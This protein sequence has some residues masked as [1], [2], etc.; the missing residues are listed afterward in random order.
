M[1]LDCGENWRFLAV[2]DTG[3]RL[4]GTE[5]LRYE[6][7]IDGISTHARVS[8]FKTLA[9]TDRTPDETEMATRRAIML[10]LDQAV[11]E[12]VLTRQRAD[13]I[14]DSTVRTLGLDRHRGLVERF[15]RGGIKTQHEFGNDPEGPLGFDTLNGTLPRRGELLD[16]TRPKSGVRS[17]EIFT[18]GYPDIP[19]A[20]S[21]EAWEAAFAKAEAEDVHKI[22][23][24][25]TVKGST[26]AEYFD[27]RTVIVVDRL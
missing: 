6:K 17:I 10:G 20:V 23:A 15:L 1:A 21:V 3:I 25:A 7:P 14:I 16:I 24:F 19:A 4:N 12:G 18:D 2:G 27:D 9:R 11:E 13:E 5:V 8:V 22:G 26:A